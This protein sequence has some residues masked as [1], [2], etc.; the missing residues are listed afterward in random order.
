MVVQPT[1]LR[2]MPLLMGEYVNGLMYTPAGAA[3]QHAYC[4]CVS[5]IMSPM[6]YHCRWEHRL[7]LEDIS[8]L[9]NACVRMEGHNS[10]I[11]EVHAFSVQALAAC[12]AL[13]HPRCPQPWPSPAVS[14]QPVRNGKASNASEYLGVPRMWATSAMETGILPALVPIESSSKAGFTALMPIGC[15]S[16]GV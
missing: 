2:E 12:E 10:S 13:L 15:T 8:C 4:S 5:S 3:V 14:E 6:Q 16:T 11:P 9:I 1:A 7:A